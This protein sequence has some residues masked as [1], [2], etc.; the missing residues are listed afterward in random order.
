M[1]GLDRAVREDGVDFNPSAE[2]G[3]ISLAKGWR[4]VE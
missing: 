3:D 4:T 1:G 2:G